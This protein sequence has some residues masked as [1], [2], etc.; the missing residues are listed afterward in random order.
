[1]IFSSLA[2]KSH[3]L[4]DEYVCDVVLLPKLARS[5]LGWTEAHLD[6]VGRYL[7]L[8]GIVDRM[9]QHLERVLDIADRVWFP[10][11]DVERYVLQAL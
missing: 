4:I 8:N 6:L 10:L 11:P 9:C 7:I 5:I 3:N 2:K 1:M